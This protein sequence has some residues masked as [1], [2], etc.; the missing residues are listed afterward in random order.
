MG[1]NKLI[2]G[3]D[4]T[5]PDSIIRITNSTV[6]TLNEFKTGSKGGCL[7]EVLKDANVNVKS[8]WLNIGKEAIIRIDGGFVVAPSTVIGVT[9]LLEVAHG[10]TYAGKVSLAASGA[11]VVVHDRG[12]LASDAGNL[13]FTTASRQNLVSISNAVARFNEASMDG[14]GDRIVLASSVVTNNSAVRIS[15]SDNTW[16]VSGDG[17]AYVA[18]NEF[19]LWGLR[20]TA[21]VRDGAQAY[22]ASSLS[23]TQN[24]TSANCGHDTVFSADGGYV[25]VLGDLVVKGNA[26]RSRI[27]SANS[28]TIAFNRNALYDVSGTN[29]VLALD[30]GE[31]AFRALLN[32][33]DQNKGLNFGTVAAS[34]HMAVEVKGTN[35]LLNVFGNFAASAATATDAPVEFRFVVPA[36][37]YVQAPIVVTNGTTTLNST[38]VIRADANAYLDAGGS[39]PIPIVQ[40]DPT[41]TFT[42]DLDALNGNAVISPNGRLFLEGATLYLRASPSFTILIIR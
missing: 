5:Y 7:I 35:S 28:G 2:A 4:N 29:T 38:L 26:D 34:A 32:G 11:K 9:G 22:I 31:V 40:G 1:C 33:V 13:A 12:V 3:E 10:G 25:A 41:K 18:K 6:T 8:Y 42:A 27:A 16:D 20:G 24:G 39:Q 15:G 21:T 37:G 19:R 17:M 14:I 30:N 23:F 36:D